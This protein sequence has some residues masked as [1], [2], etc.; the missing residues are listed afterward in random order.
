MDLGTIVLSW[1]SLDRRYLLG[2]LLSCSYGCESSECFPTKL[3]SL[4]AAGLPS[5]EDVSPR[6]SDECEC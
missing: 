1:G 2:V 4:V 5:G 3:E 6:L